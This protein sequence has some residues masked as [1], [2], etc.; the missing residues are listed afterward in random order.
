M[1]NQPQNAVVWSE[2]HVRDLDAAA[3]FYA[4]VTG[5]EAARLEMFGTPVAM[6]GAASGAGFDLQVGE[7]ARGSIVYLSAEGPLDATMARVRDAGG[8]VLTDAMKVPTGRFF[9]ASDPDGNVVGFF[10]TA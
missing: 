1:P 7:P 8:T 2:I 10:E 6:F 5:M 9:Q 4:D 3:T